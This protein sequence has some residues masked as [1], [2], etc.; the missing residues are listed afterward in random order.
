MAAVP[1]FVTLVKRIADEV[2]CISAPQY[3]FDIDPVLP[4]EYVRISLVNHDRKSGNVHPMLSLSISTLTINTVASDGIGK[5]VFNANTAPPS[6]YVIESFR[7][8]HGQISYYK[9]NC[10]QEV[11]SMDEMRKEIEELIKDIDDRVALEI[12]RDAAKELSDLCSKRRAIIERR[13]QAQAEQK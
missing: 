8:Q 3:A 6:L 9:Y 13:K 5:S 4:T 12:V 10:I 11:S 2:A 1:F 7:I